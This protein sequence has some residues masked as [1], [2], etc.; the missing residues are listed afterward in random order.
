MKTKMEL[1]VGYLYRYKSDVL[2]VIMLVI[3]DRGGS[4]P[5]Q[6]I[7]LEG[8]QPKQ[9]SYWNRYVNDKMFTEIGPAGDYPEEIL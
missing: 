7:Q 9:K 1:K 8:P 5:M 6:T 4:Y 3:K 2:D